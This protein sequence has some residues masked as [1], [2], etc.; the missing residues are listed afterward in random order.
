MISLVVECSEFVFFSLSMFCS[1]DSDDEVLVKRS[2]DVDQAKKKKHKKHKKHKKSSKTGGERDR[3]A[4]LGDKEKSKKHKKHKRKSRRVSDSTNTSLAGSA[5]EDEVVVVDKPTLSSK[6]TEIMK[7]NG[8]VAAP[9]IFPKSRTEA[10][11]NPT[12]LVRQ[13]TDSL[14]VASQIPSMEIMSSDPESDVAEVNDVDSPDVA[15]IEEELNLEDLMKQKA[16]L[17]ACLGDI[18]SESDTEEKSAERKRKAIKDPPKETTTTT[19]TSDIILLDDSSGEVVEKEAAVI[20]RKIQKKREEAQLQAAKKQKLI[21]SSRDRKREL[22]KD[23]DDVMSRDSRDRSKQR[24]IVSDRNE[25]D[26]RFKEDLRK[27]ID[28]DR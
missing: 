18:L 10:S 22:P 5:D 1:Y 8:Q 6:F 23:D 4:T 21:E 20:E 11:T 9:K 3:S 26:N 25:K 2:K 16:L 27:E 15:V 13:I 12:E 24:R 17:Q 19:T 28:R 7:S 14:R